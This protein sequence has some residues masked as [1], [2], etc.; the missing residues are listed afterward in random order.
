[1]ERLKRCADTSPA[2]DR[3]ERC[4]DM[5]FCGTASARAMSPAASPSG[6]CFTKSRNT[7]SR[8][9][10]ASAARARMASSDSIY[11][12]LAIYWAAVNEASGRPYA[13][14]NCL[15]QFVISIFLEILLTM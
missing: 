8:V 13:G 3:I 7:S 2:R 11:L 10:W 1:M 12:D 9:G 6:S 14:Q 15:E 5:V 4:D